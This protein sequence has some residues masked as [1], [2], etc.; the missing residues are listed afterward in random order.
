MLGAQSLVFATVLV[1]VV[2]P[3]ESEVR[4]YRKTLAVFTDKLQTVYTRTSLSSTTYRAIFSI[5]FE[6]VGVVIG[7]A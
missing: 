4:K 5:T 1:S 7:V 3:L 2:S 6:R